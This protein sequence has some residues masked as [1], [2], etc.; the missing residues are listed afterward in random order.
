MVR[1]KT[2]FLFALTLEREDPCF[3]FCMSVEGAIYMKKEE[4][5]IALDHFYKAVDLT[6][7]LDPRYETTKNLTDQCSRKLRGGMY[8]HNKKKGRIS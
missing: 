2:L 6:S 7:P 4:Y 1:N 3:F 5:T 8:T